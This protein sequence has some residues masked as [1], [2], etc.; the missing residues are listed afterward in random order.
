VFEGPVEGIDAPASFARVSS[1]WDIVFRE[2]TTE[3]A[4]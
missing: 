4:H 1:N 2:I 3:L